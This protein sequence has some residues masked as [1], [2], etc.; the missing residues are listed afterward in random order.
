M[1]HPSLTTFPRCAWAP[2][3]AL[4]C[5]AM[6]LPAAAHSVFLFLSLQ[7]DGTLRIETGFSDG[8]TGAGLPL[9]IHDAASGAVLQQLAMPETGIATVPAPT[10]P[11]TV[12]LDAGE[13]H[14]VTKTGPLAG[15]QG[16]AGEKQVALIDTHWGD[17]SAMEAGEKQTLRQA[18]VVL[19]PEW[20]YER[21]KDFFDEQTVVLV[22]AGVSMAKDTPQAA[23]LRDKVRARIHA[24]W[25][26]GETVVALCPVRPQDFPDWRW[27]VEEGLAKAA[28]PD[29]EPARVP[30]L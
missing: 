28:S 3:L 13:G 16:A 1:L 14:R 20:L 17:A 25:D 29:A 11:Y 21:M 8:G 23:A 30:G 4:L 18:S 5:L 7:E 2:W 15:K 9:T 22:E 6:A 12:T 24:A 26:A 27:L 10:A 19:A